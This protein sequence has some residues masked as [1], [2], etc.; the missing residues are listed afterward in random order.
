MKFA[1]FSLL[2]SLD[3]SWKFVGCFSAK[4]NQIIVL[5]I[6]SAP[7]KK[8]NPARELY[9]TI[10]CPYFNSTCPSLLRK[11]H[12]LIFLNKLNK[13]VVKIQHHTQHCIPVFT[14]QCF[15]A[16]KVLQTKCIQPKSCEGNVTALETLAGSAFHQEARAEQWKQ[17]HFLNTS[18]CLFCSP[19]YTLTEHLIINIIQVF[20]YG[21]NKSK[22]E[23][24]NVKDECPQVMPLVSIF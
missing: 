21:D 15:V 9:F 22:E 23:E 10:T 2:S 5:W 20:G 11:V 16:V 18:L 1:C 19:I 24:Q 14:A 17:G 3:T 6:L 4:P 8:P 13:E 7:Q 12:F